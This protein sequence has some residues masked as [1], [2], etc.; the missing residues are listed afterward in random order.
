MVFSRKGIPSS[1]SA[2]NMA[3]KSEKSR[4]H[5]SPQGSGFLEYNRGILTLVSI[6]QGAKVP[7]SEW[8]PKPPQ[9]S[10]FWVLCLVNSQTEFL[11]QCR[12]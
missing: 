9:A 1:S 4:A 10:G 8:P 7:E 12:G 5:D 11:G 3:K 2:P 6:P